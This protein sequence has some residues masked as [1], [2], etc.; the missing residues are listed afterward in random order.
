MSG[1]QSYRPA[2]LEG[3]RCELTEHDDGYPAG[4][5]DGEGRPPKLYVLGD[6]A[7]L[8]RPYVAIIGARKAT[9]YGIACAQLSARCAVSM[10]IGVVSG[11]AIGCDQAAQREALRL[12]GAVVAVLGSGANVI[13]P[14]RASDM[15]SE[16][17]RTGGAIVSLQGWDAPP[18]KWAFVRRN[19]VIALLSR[20]LVICEAGLP[21]G[22][23]STAQNASDAGREVLVFPGS[24]FSPNST[25]SN[26]LIASDIN[27]LPVWDEQC[28]QIA[29]SRNFGRLCSAPGHAP[30]EARTSYTP[31]EQR[32]LDALTA[33]PTSLGDL[34]TALGLSSSELLRR[35]GQLEVRGCVRRLMDGRYSLTEHELLAQNIGE[36][37]EHVSSQSDGDK[38]GSA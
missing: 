30:S 14:A 36:L 9:P 33:S 23:F 21:S 20:V 15:L 28:L 32:V 8:L 27:T 35:L 12:G 26:Y 29:F 6:P 3:P 2:R 5:L 37:R 24:V 18:A 22:T 11:A 38:K 34:A 19:A 10:G 17:L 16:I 7:A 4:L 1:A 25:G 13:Y 31:D